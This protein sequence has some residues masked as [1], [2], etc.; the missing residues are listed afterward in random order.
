MVV[1]HKTEK[2]RAHTKPHKTDKL[3]MINQLMVKMFQSGFS[4]EN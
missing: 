1:D 4:T 3:F 2:Y